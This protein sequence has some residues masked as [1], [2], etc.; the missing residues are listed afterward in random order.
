MTPLEK[1]GLAC[2]REH[3]CE[4]ADIDG[5][6]A[7]DKATELG[8]LVNVRVTEPCGEGCRCVEYDDF[9]QDC[10]R[11]S[12]EMQRLIGEQKP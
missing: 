7:Q 12:D 10:L 8:L 6:W 9:P 2:L 1:F 5:G 4:I 3:R 11:Y